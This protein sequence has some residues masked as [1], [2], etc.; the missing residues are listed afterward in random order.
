[1]LILPILSSENLF[2]FFFFFIASTEKN[3][4][5]VG[6]QYIY[7]VIKKN[8]CMY[9]NVFSNIVLF[10]YI[11]QLTI[12]AILLSVYNHTEQRMGYFFN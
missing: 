3:G 2:N 7:I 8:N 11:F 9:F 5:I 1:M 6:N 4:S 10:C 12:Y